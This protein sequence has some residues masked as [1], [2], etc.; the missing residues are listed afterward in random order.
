V[1]I[2]ANLPRQDVKLVISDVP[3]IRNLPAIASHMI[4]T[5]SAVQARMAAVRALIRHLRDG[6]AA[7]I[8]P[9][10]RVDPD[11]EVLPG[12]SEGLAAW[13][14]S[15]ELVLKQ[16]PQTRLLISIVSGVLAPSCLGSPFTRLIDEPWRRLKLAEFIQIIQQ[17][18]L[19]RRFGL[20]PKVYFDQ[21][22]TASDLLADAASDDIQQAII[23]RARQTLALHLGT[24]QFK[25]PESQISAA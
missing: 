9:S 24:F 7:L 11:P 10:G 18:V 20:R 17:L 14:P 4:F 6:G 16:V 3:F 2:L 19:K 8:F 15:L 12:A 13:S 23:Q 1:A 5:P 21:P 22:L 25:S